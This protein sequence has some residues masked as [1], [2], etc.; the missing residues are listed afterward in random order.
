MAANYRLIAVQVGDALKYQTSINEINRIGCAIFR[1]RSERF[2]NEA[3]TSSRAQLVH[4][5]ILTLAKQLM[6][7]GERDQLLKSF[8]DQLCPD[9]A[10]RETIH[11]ILEAAGVASDEAKSDLREFL[12]RAFHPQVDTHCRKLFS[13]GN[14]FHAVFEAC[15]LY[16]KMVREK[17]MSAKDGEPLML[18]VWGWENGVLKVT[19]CQSDTDKNVQDGVKFLSAGL[20]RAVRNP[21][22]REPALPCPISKEDCLDMLSFVSFLFRQIDKAVYYKTTT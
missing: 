14:Y 16:N 3:I 2:P 4:D 12:G 5:W 1:F 22:A 17:A 19:A 10:L 8:C 7:E 13:Q 6:A 21:T 20:M 18:D 11:S 9:D 15:K